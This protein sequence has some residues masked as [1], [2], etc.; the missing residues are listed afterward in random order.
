MTEQEA[1][2]K[3]NQHLLTLGADLNDYQTPSARL[4]NDE[5]HL[6]YNETVLRV[7]KH[8]S[9]TVHDLTGATRSC[10]GA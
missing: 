2:T 7:G 8:V 6:T 10:A 5:W 1:I 9:V 3:A 4:V